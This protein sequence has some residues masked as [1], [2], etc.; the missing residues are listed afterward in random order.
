MP[1]LTA[2]DPYDC[3][4]TECLTG[5]Y[6]PLAEATDD[7][8]ADML[9]GRLADHTG[10]ELEI[11]VTWVTD[12]DSSYRSILRFDTMTVTLPEGRYLTYP[13]T[14]TPDPYRVGLIK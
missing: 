9:A 13:R 10:V 11:T 12:W 8:I 4:C 5:E 3:G 6:K 1:R 14:W 2:I 7:D